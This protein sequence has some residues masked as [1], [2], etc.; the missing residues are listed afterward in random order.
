MKDDVS[1]DRHL[2]TA[3]ALTDDARM[4]LGSSAR[5][6]IFVP[7]LGSG[8]GRSG[9]TDTQRTHDA[10]LAEI[11]GLSAAIQLEQITAQ[12]V[13]VPQTR[14][15]TL[16]GPGK[17]EDLAA[18]IHDHEI[19]V[20]VVDH[21]LS[22]VQ[23]RN[24]ERAWK[25]KVLD[26]TGLILE[27]FGARAQTREGTLQVELAHLDYQK[28]RLVRSWTHLERQRGGVGFL[29]G[30]G[31]RQ[32]ESDRRQLQT[33]IDAIR[34]ELS[35]VSRTR[36]L[37]RAGRR[38][39]PYPIVALVGYTNAG[40]STLFNRLTGAEVHAEDQLFA[41]L[42]PTMREVRLP[43]GRK[44]I[45]SDT[46]GFIS[47]LPTTLIAAFRATLEEVLEAHIILHVRD[48][49][50]DDTEAQRNDVLAVMKEL[51]IDSEAPDRPIVEVW[52]K[53]DLLNVAKREI[54]ANTLARQKNGP[55]LLSALTG[56]GK[57]D[58]FSRIDAILAEADHDLHLRIAPEHGALMHWLYEHGDVLERAD[59]DDGMM[60]LT[61][62]LSTANAERLRAKIET[63]S[64]ELVE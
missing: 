41:T 1:V 22:P 13:S 11:T 4:K 27:I 33:R 52:N 61:V 54:H 20:A 12:I 49:T 42:D 9:A 10:R 63:P 23:Q 44:I 3:P 16:F 59:A 26:R 56:E 46:V 30:P 14:P 64:R 7:A 39:V 40:K 58:L 35:A 53:A 31:E 48:I 24:L 36:E 38:R 21:P 2:D 29:G 60:Q 37:H 62:R 57:E 32:I 55:V 8:R 45:L 5:A 15:A 43:S 6:G 18:L 25:C 47:E 19:E 51:G 34:K 28:S 17:V 50:H